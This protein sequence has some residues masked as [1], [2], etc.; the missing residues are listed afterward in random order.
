MLAADRGREARLHAAFD[1]AR[2]ALP[3][4]LEEVAEHDVLAA[5]TCRELDHLAR[6]GVQVVEEPAG[7]AAA[8]AQDLRL[9]LAVATLAARLREQPF[10][11]RR[12]VAGTQRGA[13]LAPSLSVSSW[14]P[15]SAASSSRAAASP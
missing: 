11:R 2:A 8:L 12:G 13:P 7:G 14:G 6:A 15:A 4:V 3:G 1:R 10:G 9:Q 5:G